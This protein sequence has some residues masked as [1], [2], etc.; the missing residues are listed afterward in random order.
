MIL[1]LFPVS[2]FVFLPGSERNKGVI[3]Y[4]EFTAAASIIATNWQYINLSNLYLLQKQ[5]KS[6]FITEVLDSIDLFT[7][8]RIVGNDYS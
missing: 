5:V 7:G 6:Q 4:K 8:Q 3:Q 1:S 2:L